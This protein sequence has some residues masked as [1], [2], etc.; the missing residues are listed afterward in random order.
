MLL[1]KC[2][3]QKNNMKIILQLSLLFSFLMASCQSKMDPLQAEI[4]EMESQLQEDV[5]IDT[6]LAKRI[7]KA[8]LKYV[9]QHPEDSLAPVYLSR[10][11]DIMKEIPE[12]R[13]KSVNIYNRVFTEYPNH[14]LAARSIF[15]VGFVF[16]EKYDDSKRAIKSYDFFL[17]KFPDH[18]LAE[19]ARN[20]RSLRQSD[21]DILG[22]IKEWKE[23]AD[24]STTKK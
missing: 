5:S 3:S 14:E 15:M 9:D 7:T 2:V 1:T 4:Q 10:S 8:Y 23:K 16:D 12:L 13:L 22:Q 17:E 20:L 6:S 11:A 18:E 19:Q 21:Q 24:S